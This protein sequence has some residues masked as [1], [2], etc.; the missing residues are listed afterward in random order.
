MENHVVELTR[1]QRAHGNRVCL[2]TAI[3]DLT[4]ADDIRVLAR[5]QVA[6][7]RPQ[8]LRDLLFCVAAR[9]ALGL[10]ARRF[11]VVHVHGDWSAFL[12]ARLVASRVGARTLVAS[13]HGRTRRSAVFAPVYRAVLRGYA[14]CYATG[15]DDARHLSAACGREVP[16][17]TSGVP[18]EWPAANA[19]SCA[20]V[21]DP[22]DVLCVGTLTAVKNLPLAIDIARRMPDLQFAIVGDGPD[23]AA[24]ASAASSAPNVR[25]MGRLARSALPAVYARSRVLL[26]TSISEGTPT[27]M[28]EAMAFG[29]PI[30]TS[31]SNDYAQVLPDAR[32]GI[33]VE[34]PEPEHF[35]RAL[36]HYLGSADAL[37]QARAVNRARAE[38]FTWPRIARRVT[39]LMHDDRVVP[40]TSKEPASP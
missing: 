5:W 29:L 20:A 13:V 34:P 31:R 2:L 27:V 30:V 7:W 28:L 15:L 38:T 26:S 19:T 12:F 17:I 32:H 4:S 25:F 24:L 39:S 23:R 9:Q 8:L 35:V 14:A 33:V 40:S 18:T 10:Q 6:R 37:A 11:D 1:Q 21:T 3:G 22:I 36:R 16:W